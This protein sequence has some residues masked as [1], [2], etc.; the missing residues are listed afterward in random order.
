[1]TTTDDNAPRARWISRVAF[2]IAAAIVLARCL[3]LEIPRDPNVG[4]PDAPGGPGA[5]VSVTLDW[6]C[7][8]PVG[9]LLARRLLDATFTLRFTI[10]HAFAVALAIWTFASVGWASDHF[11]ALV[12]SL[13]VVGGVALFWTFSQLVRRWDQLRVVAG[14]AAGVLLANVAQGVIY[15][16]VEFPALLD[17]WQQNKTTV[18]EQNGWREGDYSAQRY[19]LKLKAGELLGFN[20][21]ANTLAAICVMTSLTALG[22]AAQRTEDRDDP[23]WTGVCFLIAATALFPLYYCQSKAAY[24]AFALGVTLLGA[25]RLTRR[26]LASHRP[27]MFAAGA[28]AVGLAIVGAIGYGLARG[29]LPTDSLNFRWRYWVGS[30]PMWTEHPT[31]GVGWANF[32]TPYLAHRVPTAAEEIVD[33]HDLLVR[34]A[35]ELGGVGLALGVAWLLAWAWQAARPP[36]IVARQSEAL[37]GGTIRVQP[38]LCVV[39][40]AYTLNV[41]CAVDLT[42]TD[43]DRLNYAIIELLKRAVLFAAVALGVGAVTLTARRVASSDRVAVGYHVDDRPAPWIAAGLFASTAMLL[44][45][46]TIDM[47][48]FETGP[49]ALALAIMGALLGLARDDRPARR[50]S[51]ALV[52]LVVGGV[53]AL[54]L[55]VI[56]VVPTDVAES[57]AHDGDRFATRQPQRSLDAYERA[58]AWS[59]GRNWSYPER[60]TRVAALAGDLPRAVALADVTVAAD[61]ARPLAYLTRAR[62]R[63]TVPGLS[64]G[65]VAS[66]LS[67]LRQAVD[68]NPNDVDTRVEYAA[69]LERFGRPREAADQLLAALDADDALDAAEPKRLSLRAP[70]VREQLQARASRLRGA[71]TP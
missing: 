23:G 19:E 37:S 66:I 20:A 52:A 67:D 28:C 53:I 36:R 65:D 64:A 44:L 47:A 3:M 51:L 9:L 31:L 13:N 34:W 32:A 18:L 43:G 55:L 57:F 29:S 39:A 35:V 63:S 15:R 10:A 1:M 49:F 42:I 16:T 12:G 45:Q 61:P 33:P 54:A 70:G 56:V 50:D 22:A 27:L 59:V 48:F 62:L 6:L 30:W 4:A 7:L 21:S 8:V 46:S 2:A 58:A 11:A 5:G 40:L 38:L 60:A 69:S 14:L 68:R 24:A 17:Y 26:W 71:G 41:V 25:W